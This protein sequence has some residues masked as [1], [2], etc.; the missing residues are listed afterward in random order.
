MKAHWCTQQTTRPD[1]AFFAPRGVEQV[2]MRESRYGSLVGQYSYRLKSPADDQDEEEEGELEKAIADAR[3]PNGKLMV[4]LELNNEQARRCIAFAMQQDACGAQRTRKAGDPRGTEGEK[5]KPFDAALLPRM[6]INGDALPGHTVRALAREMQEQIYSLRVQLAYERNWTNGRAG[7]EVF[8]MPVAGVSKMDREAR[9]RDRA[10]RRTLETCDA[11]LNGIWHLVDK[12]DGSSGVEGMENYLACLI[13][14]GMPGSGARHD[15]R[16]VTRR[17]ASLLWANPHFRK[18]MEICRRMTKL[19]APA[20]ILAS[21]RKGHVGQ[22]QLR[23]M[24]RFATGQIWGNEKLLQAGRDA[25][26]YALLWVPMG[27]KVDD[28][29]EADG[30][31]PTEVAAAQKRAV[32]RTRKRAH[33]QAQLEA[34]ELE[35]TR[36]YMQKQREGGWQ[37]YNPDGEQQPRQQQPGGGGTH[38]PAAGTADDAD[39]EEEGGDDDGAH[40]LEEDQS[41]V[42]VVSCD[43]FRE[44]DGMHPGVRCVSPVSAVTGFG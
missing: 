28:Y 16:W 21:Q 35:L 3:R 33:E 27:E 22:R 8:E 38:Q 25:V 7:K 9:A 11:H 37:G 34:A 31:N 18:R 15:Q 43:F 40:A 19:W 13:C 41:P 4:E 23:A 10:S 6:A 44:M 39:E 26:R 17:L 5:F 36:T 24:R 29:E 30:Q 14:R 20:E 32:E 12:P 42:G 2:M 1:T